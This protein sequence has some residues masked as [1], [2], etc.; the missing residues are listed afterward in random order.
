M[1]AIIPLFAASLLCS[2]AA[3]AS[4]A[5]EFSV[6]GKIT[7]GACYPTLSEHSVDFGEIK[8]TELERHTAT[9]LDRD[10]LTTLDISCEAATLF[11]VRGVD[12]R[13]GSVGNDWYRSAYGLGLTDRGERIG[14]H[15]VEVHPSLSSIDGV[16]LYTTYSDAY[17][18]QWDYAGAEPSG[19]PNDGRLLGFT[20]KRGSGDGPVP[21][22][23][24]RLGLN[25]FVVVAPASE[26]TLTDDVLL[27]GKAT[28]ELIYL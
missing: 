1:K 18:Q 4:S 14:A 15:Y 3:L 8:V 24:A 9:Q 17:G 20:T 21:I 10:R 26:L 25:H 5:V 27:D 11:S 12:D 28:I 23:D 22:K 2:T 7:P 19:I 6:V 13:A 16:P